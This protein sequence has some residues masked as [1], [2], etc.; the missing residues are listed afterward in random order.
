M[1]V[2]QQPRPF[3]RR[4][5]RDDAYSALCEAIVT[6][7]LA[8]GEQL[9]DAELCAW[10]GLSRT[11]VRDAL[12]RLEDEGLVETAPQRFTRVAPLLSRD[13]QDTFPVLASLHAL[14]AE[15]G[16]PRLRREDLDR[17]RAENRAF[18]EALTINDPE[19]AYSADDRFHRIFVDA[20]GNP[21]I[22]R[23]LRRL[24]PRLRR[25]EHL[26]AGVLPGRRSLAQH[27]AIISRAA[28]RDAR[29]TASATRENWLEFGALVQRSLTARAC[30]DA[31]HDAPAR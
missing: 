7:T 9:H 23:V 30:E 22:D 13:A 17:L 20:S 11:P 16:T 14:A 26:R 12:A 10:L 18:H 15:L 28:A 4:L 1:P 31:G 5:L 27:E 19:L 8:P 21:E 29:A 24:G 3:E 2:P 6:G 25:L